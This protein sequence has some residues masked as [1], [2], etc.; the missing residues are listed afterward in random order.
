MS[1]RTKNQKRFFI[2]F[3]VLTLGTSIFS[4]PTAQA[5][6]FSQFFPTM[7]YCENHIHAFGLQST[8][9]CVKVGIGPIAELKK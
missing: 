5:I 9:H 2:G 1:R 3:L 8:H 4:A 7:T 6:Q